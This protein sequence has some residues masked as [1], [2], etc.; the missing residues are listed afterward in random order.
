[1][2]N[3]CAIEYPLHEAP[4]L[5]YFPIVEKWIVILAILHLDSIVCWE[6][7]CLCRK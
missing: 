1:M 3:H 4:S 6:S 2:N 5:M 7:R